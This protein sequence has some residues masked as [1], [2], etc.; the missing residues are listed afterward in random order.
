MIV[1]SSDGP[2]SPTRPKVAL[3][4]TVIRKNQLF[5]FLFNVQGVMS[6]KILFYIIP[7]VG[8]L[9]ETTVLASIIKL[10]LVKLSIQMYVDY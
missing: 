6:G 7:P 10:L 8:V 1:A 4:Y 3:T 5:F 2:H 9:S